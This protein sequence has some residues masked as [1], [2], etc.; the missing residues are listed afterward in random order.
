VDGIAL[1]LWQMAG[2]GMS[3][4][5]LQSFATSVYIIVVVVVVIIIIIIIVLLEKLKSLS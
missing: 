4:V 5:E 3:D 1:G 2:F